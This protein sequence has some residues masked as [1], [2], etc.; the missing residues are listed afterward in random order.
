MGVSEVV[1]GFVVG[2]VVE[3]VVVD[4][5]VGVEGRRGD[6]E[7]LYENDICCRENITSMVLR[8]KPVTESH[9]TS[10]LTLASPLP[11]TSFI[12]LTSQNLTVLSNPAVANTNPDDENAMVLIDCR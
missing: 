5:E 6:R 11:T 10:S 7:V 12:P 8:D 1:V 4:D 3:P 2:V 9:L